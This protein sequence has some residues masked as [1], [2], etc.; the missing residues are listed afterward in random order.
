MLNT[1]QLSLT[2]L[3]GI[4][5]PMLNAACD[6][7]NPPAIHQAFLGHYAMSQIGFR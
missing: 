6:S 1:A 2:L 7:Y 3:R 4:H 5:C